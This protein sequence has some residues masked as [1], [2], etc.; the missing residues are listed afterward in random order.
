MTGVNLD[1]QPLNKEKSVHSF[2]TSVP[3]FLFIVFLYL[4]LSLAMG[5]RKVYFDPL[6]TQ[7]DDP[8]GTPKP[9]PEAVKA[10]AEPWKVGEKGGT[11]AGAKAAPPKPAAEEDQPQS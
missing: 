8:E 4:G 9:G 5:A 11:A 1:H 7:P 2:N 6:T 3:L 10:G